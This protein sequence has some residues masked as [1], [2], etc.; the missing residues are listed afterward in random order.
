MK[1]RCRTCLHEFSDDSGPLPYRDRVHCVLC[2]AAIP[3]P[4]VHAPTD[5][6]P[7]S[8]EAAR[9]ADFALGVLNAA[10]HGFPD[11]LRQF[12]VRQPARPR[13]STSSSDTLMPLTG[14]DETVHAAAPARWWG[15]SFWASLGMG[16]AVGGLL[17][18]GFAVSHRG[19]EPSRGTAPASARLDAPPQA[20]MPRPAPLPSS[21]PSSATAAAPPAPGVAVAAASPKPAPRVF[22]AMAERR[23]ALERARAEQRSYHLA[24]A[25]RLYARILARSP[26]DSEALAGLGELE[27]LRGTTDLAAARFRDALSANADYVPARIAV[28]DLEWQAGHVEA[29]RQAY[30]EI[31]QAYTTDLY[32]PYVA[33]R[34]QVGEPANC[35]Q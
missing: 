30:R 32:P 9:E 6:P 31:V 26:R 24:E 5:L 21:P 34:S 28:A 14:A 11:T 27:L 25:E 8:N 2:G 4:R 35:D 13:S 10:G 3:L 16:F 1:H 17:A 29:A 19:A 7:F 20:Q 22:D 33:Q 15:V 12:R 23:F 18:Y